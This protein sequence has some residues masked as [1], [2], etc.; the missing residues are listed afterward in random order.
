MIPALPCQY[1]IWPIPL[2]GE[3]TEMRWC[4]N[5][6]SLS[7]YLHHRS[8]SYPCS[9]KH[10]KNVARTSVP[11]ANRSN[12]DDPSS[13]MYIQCAF[14]FPVRKQK[15]CDASAIPPSPPRRLPASWSNTCEGIQNQEHRPIVPNN[16]LLYQYLF[17][18]P[19]SELLTYFDKLDH[20]SLVARKWLQTC[21]NMCK[22][23]KT[24]NTT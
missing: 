3:A 4:Q 18:Q 24:R 2:P 21:V 6:L 5:N 9:R 23:F 17:V 10:T 20:P 19:R 1:T 14:L 11:R 22:K 13:P 15:W 12:D 8:D 7:H 16:V